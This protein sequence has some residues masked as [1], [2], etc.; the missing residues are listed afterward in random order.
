MSNIMILRNGMRTTPDDGEGSSRDWELRPCGMVVQVRDSS[1]DNF[2][3]GPLIKVKVSYGRSIHEV[4]IA[5][6]STFGDLKN[7][8]TLGTGL[9]PQQQRLLY[10]GKEKDNRVYLHDAGVRNKSKIVLIEDPS[11]QEKRLVE[12]RR[13]EA[14]AMACRAVADVN[15]EVDMI[16]E[17]VFAVEAA[18]KSGRRL[19]ESAIA[20]PTELL[21]CQLLKLDS[22]EAEGE[23]KSQRRILVRRVQKYVET[24]DMLKIQNEAPMTQRTVVTTKWETF[25]AGLVGATSA[26][27]QHSGRML[28][29]TATSSAVGAVAD[30]KWFN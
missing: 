8:L 30:W 25:D 21:M 23:A 27:P 10:R 24:L 6:F 15:E 14:I 19:K 11:S 7:L 18:V 16:A 13:D 26:R 20:E 28:P 4:S 9:E 1:P 29:Q 5:A 2:Q 22:I 3:A 12:S 17:K